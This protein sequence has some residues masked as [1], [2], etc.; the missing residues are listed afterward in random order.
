M[1]RPTLLDF[2][3]SF[4][5]S[6]SR[7]ER[8]GIHDALLAF[9]SARSQDPCRHR[10]DNENIEEETSESGEIIS[11]SVITHLFLIW[12]MRKSKLLAGQRESEK[13]YISLQCFRATDG[14]GLC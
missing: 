8:N 10:V 13:V 5:G 14:S 6:Q 3:T 7:Q 9:E 2:Q 11:T 4:Y 12:S 1:V